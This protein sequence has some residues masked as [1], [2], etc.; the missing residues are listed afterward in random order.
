[1]A[2]YR[3]NKLAIESHHLRGIRIHADDAMTV[4]CQAARRYHADI[5]KPECADPQLALFEVLWSDSPPVFQRFQEGIAKLEAHVFEDLRN[6][7]G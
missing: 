1:M 4:L 5:A 2:E 7:V 3:D 6:D